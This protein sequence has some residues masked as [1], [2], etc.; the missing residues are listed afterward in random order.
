ML[1]I[2]EIDTKMHIGTVRDLFVEYWEWLGFDGCF[3]GFDEE[4]NTL[5][6]RYAPPDGCILLALWE[7]EPAG[8]VALRR[9][10]DRGC[11][12]KRLYVRPTFRGRRIGFAMA[13]AIVKEARDRRY[14]YMRL[15]TLPVM[16]NA[17]A[18]YRSLGFKEITPYGSD[19]TPGAKY[20]ELVL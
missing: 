3:Q 17:I 10:E 19:P 20:M 14:A 7:S 13:S 9:L 15:D 1:R 2:I 18:L 12:M 8:C 16:K 5:P 11:E 6:G 4:L